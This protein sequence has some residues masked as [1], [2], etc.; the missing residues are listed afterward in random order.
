MTFPNQ[1]QDELTR[2][3][4]QQSSESNWYLSGQLDETG[5]IRRI[6]LSSTPFRVGR[7][8]GLHLSIPGGCVSKEHAEIFQMEDQLW[9]RDLGSTNG[10]YVNGARIE[11]ETRVIEGDLVQ[12]ASLVFRIGRDQN[13]T[14]S[15]TQHEDACDRA[16]VM[17]QFDRLI[18]DGGGHSLL[19]T[20]CF[21]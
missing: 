3:D 1:F 7:R 11:S 19:S 12:F 18:S 8:S 5:E 20:N 10:T 21:D 4:E 2:E 6:E 13:F 17:M 16:L 9:V 14:E 15:H